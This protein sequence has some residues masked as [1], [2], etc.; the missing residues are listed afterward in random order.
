MEKSIVSKKISIVSYHLR[1]KLYMK[2]T[3]LLGKHFAFEKV[4]SDFGIA[5]G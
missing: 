4:A 3:K 1:F 2:L 5:G